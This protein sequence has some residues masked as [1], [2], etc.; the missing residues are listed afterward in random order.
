MPY[1]EW[2]G[3]N[4]FHALATSV[5][6]GELRRLSHPEWCG[7]GHAPET[8][9][10]LT[11]RN[12]EYGLHWLLYAPLP[13][14]VPAVFPVALSLRGGMDDVFGALA[15]AGGRRGRGFW[16][17]PRGGNILG[18]WAEMGRGRWCTSR[19]VSTL[20]FR[21]MS[22][23]GIWRWWVLFVRVRRGWGACRSNLE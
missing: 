10:H 6:F 3:Y 23:R 13:G 22:L 19:L 16:L 9:P 7:G 8:C 4:P 17:S 2:E 11:H 14:C 20:F 1:E 15:L 5:S 18:A 21:D 12:D